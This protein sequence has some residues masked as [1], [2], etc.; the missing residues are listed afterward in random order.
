M[1]F[2]GDYNP[3]QWDKPTIDKDVRLMK[4][5]HVNCV[6]LGVFSWVALEPEEGVFRFEW[7]DYIMDKMYQ[8]GVDVILATP[9]TA[10]PF[11]LS[12]KYPDILH[13]DKHGR[14]AL[15]GH[16]EKVCYNSEEYRK[17]TRII[18]G[19]LA[20]RYA[21]HPALKLW[22]INNEYHYFCYCDAC[23]KAFRQ[24]CMEKYG[25]LEAI[26][27]AWNT[28]FWGHTYTDIDQILP[29]TYLS[30]VYEN[31]LGHKDVAA[32]QGL[33]IDYMR[34]MSRSVRACIE[35]EKEAIRKYSQLPVTNNFS[36]FGRFYDYREVAKPLDIISWDNYPT[37]HT[38]MYR[39]A[40]YHDL[41]RSI[42]DK[43]FLIMEQNPNNLSWEDVGPIKRP[44]EVSDICWQS[45]AHGADASLFFQWRQSVG[46]VE[47]FH[48]GMIPHSG[49][50]DTRM[51][52]ELKDLGAQLAALDNIL[53]GAEYPVRAAIISEW[54]DKWALEGSSIHNVNIKHMEEVI[55]YYRAFYELGVQIDVIG[56]ENLLEKPYDIVVAP[57]AFLSS[58]QFSEDV[59]KY[60]RDGG[61][62]VTTFFSGIAEPSD[63]VIL[64]GY[65]GAFREVLGLWVEEIDGIY[66]GAVNHI[67]MNDGTR[68]TCD[69][70]CDI[71]R[72]EG[73][74]AL[75]VYGDDF[76]QG[77]PCVTK[78]A[79]GQGT[80]Y[81]I[82][83]SPEF[84]FV[85]KVLSSL[86]LEKNIPVY[87]L[88]EGVEMCRREKNETVY[89]FLMNHGN[90]PAE[91][92]LQEEYWDFFTHKTVSGRVSLMSRQC[93]MLCKG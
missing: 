47:K 54:E 35:N 64:G 50:L 4:E 81:Y 22:H 83:T 42:K 39:P 87:S 31:N 78:H 19:K 48:G 14:R 58:K 82:G 26:N 71:I 68:Y 69:E 44:R 33:F 85:K 86:C 53:S 21:N 24:W 51:G 70:I 17:H 62:F 88:P 77:T 36:D 30:D 38:P 93:M 11:W 16:R 15:G 3:E 63:N 12:K 8:N 29:P 56:K 79:Y 72:L 6:T 41:M 32:F 1:W 18:A 2:G 37:L 73:A 60:V 25:S 74:E 57:C 27:K 67:V 5:L 23:A 92:E 40:Y 89:T 80:A 34:F 9:T 61:L 76:Y 66:P 13:V 43:P 20:E 7:L 46:G 10:P 90:S 84:D 65:P 28:A 52:K 45:I 59:K 55:K 75:G 49:R 91:V